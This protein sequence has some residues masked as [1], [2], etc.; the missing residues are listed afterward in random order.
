MRYLYHI[1]LALGFQDEAQL[2]SSPTKSPTK[3]PSLPKSE[4]SNKSGKSAHSS[5]QKKPSIHDEEFVVGQCRQE[6]CYLIFCNNDPYKSPAPSWV[7]SN[8]QC[9]LSLSKNS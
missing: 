5:L 3:A 7:N 2:P 6:K 1:I 4:K 8:I 9:Q